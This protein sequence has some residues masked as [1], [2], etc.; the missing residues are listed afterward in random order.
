MIKNLFLHWKTCLKK[1]AVFPGLSF[2]AFIALL[3][4]TREGPTS[5]KHAA[6]QHLGVAL[7]CPGLTLGFLLWIGSRMWK[8]GSVL[9]NRHVRQK[10]LQLFEGQ[11]S[12]KGQ[13]LQ[14]QAHHCSFP[15]DDFRVRIMLSR[16]SSLSQARSLSFK[17]MPTLL[18]LLLYLILSISHVSAV[19][20]FSSRR[21]DN[22]V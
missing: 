17:S 9:S 4:K 5:F 14:L 7:V 15:K 8:L 10:N 3:Q 18:S 11:Q 20:T 1:A 21:C 13:Q 12:T 16:S 2:V 22:P 19:L 6:V